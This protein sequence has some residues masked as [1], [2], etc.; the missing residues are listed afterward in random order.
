MDEILKK[1]SWKVFST[2]FLVFFEVFY[3]ENFFPSPKIPQS[4]WKRP[5]VVS[6]Q[7]NVF[8]KNNYSVEECLLHFFK[9]FQLGKKRFT[10]F[11]G[12][13]QKL[14]FSMF[15]VKEKAVFQF[16]GCL[17]EGILLATLWVS[18]SSAF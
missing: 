2:Q 12:A 5:T 16:Y 15:R 13:F 17:F 14:D 9:R 1:N 18:Y 7:G 3:E 11:G 4:L 10:N 6:A 8:S